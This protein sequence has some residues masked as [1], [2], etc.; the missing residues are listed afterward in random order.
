MTEEQVRTAVQKAIALVAPEAA[1]ISLQPKV[2]FRDQFE[3]DSMDF[4][5]FVLALDKALKRRTPEVDY[6]RLSSLAG[7]VAYLG[8]TRPAAASES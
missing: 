1:A 5:S 7:C 8:E 3:F 4:V 6:P 2:N